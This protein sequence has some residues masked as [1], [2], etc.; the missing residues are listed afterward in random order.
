MCLP[1]GKKKDR[2]SLERSEENGEESHPN[3]PANAPHSDGRKRTQE[4]AEKILP[5]GKKMVRASL[6]QSKKNGEGAVKRK[7]LR[8]KVH[9]SAKPK[10]SENTTLREISTANLTRTA[11]ARSIGSGTFGTCYPGKYRGI[12]VVIKKIQ[13]KE[14]WRR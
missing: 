11:A 12:D 2:A 8:R 3:P 4:E 9:A 13:R 14:L 6:E 5:R 7:T 10:E 1:G